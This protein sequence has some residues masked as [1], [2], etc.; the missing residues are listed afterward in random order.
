M[1]RGNTLHGGANPLFENSTWQVLEAG[2]K[3]VVLG[4]ISPAGAQVPPS[5]CP[6][7]ASAGCNTHT[8]VHAEHPVT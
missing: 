8:A 7:T 2:P 6:L 4:F 1:H 3:E 5:V